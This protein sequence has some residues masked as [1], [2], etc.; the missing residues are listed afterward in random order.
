MDRCQ[1]GAWGDIWEHLKRCTKC[2]RGCNLQFVRW[3]LGK[4][5]W[6][7]KFR[8]RTR[9]ST[10]LH[11]VQFIDNLAHKISLTYSLRCDRNFLC[12]CGVPLK[13]IF[14]CTAVTFILL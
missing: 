4:Y 1:D 5:L 12:V 10:Y 2:P 9:A 7:L 11:F 8:K 14:R 3:R 6:P 13:F